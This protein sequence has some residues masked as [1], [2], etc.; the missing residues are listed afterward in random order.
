MVMASADSLRQI[1][2]IRQLTTGGSRC[3]VLRQLGQLRGL[4][5]IAIG[6]GSLRGGLQVGGNLLRYVLIIRGV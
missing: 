4:G 1:L 5:G 6:L 3:E 2:N